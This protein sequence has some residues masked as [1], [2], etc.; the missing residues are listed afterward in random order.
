[1]W[2]NWKFIPVAQQHVS[3]GLSGQSFSHWS[4]FLSSHFL[5]K[6][7]YFNPTRGAIK[8]MGPSALLKAQIH[9]RTNLPGN[10]L[11][12]IHSLI[13]SSV[14][15][16]MFVYT[17]IHLFKYSVSTCQF[18]SVAQS[19][20]T[21][22][23]PM[24]CSMPGFPAHHQFPEL[25][26]THVHRASD[27]IQPSHPLSSPSLPAFSLTQHQGLFQW[28]SSSH[29]VARVLELQLQHQCFE[30]IFRVDFL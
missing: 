9:L 22:C 3:W 2:H 15:L 19:C 23:N 6:L 11:S 28:V 5:P 20:P 27:A 14:S 8:K 13:N 4:S 16:L 29:Q 10:W 7:C 24:D 30:W 12:D 25:T 26:Q 18:S 21:L 1:M 17:S